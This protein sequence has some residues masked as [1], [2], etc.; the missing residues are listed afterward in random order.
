VDVTP[1]NTFIAF[2]AQ[3]G[4][5]ASDDGLYAREL[6][7]A[8]K[9]ARTLREA[10]DRA[11]QAGDRASN[12]KQRP[13][14]DDGLNADIGLRGGADSSPPQQLAGITPRPDPGAADDARR[15]EDD[16][17]AEAR[18]SDTV[19]AYEAYK[20]GYPS[21]RYVASANVAIARLKAASVPASSEGSWSTTVGSRPQ[22]GQTFRDC[23]D[24]PEM[25]VIPAGSF[26]MGSPASEVGRDKDEGPQRSVN[27]KSVAFG[28][29]HITRGQ[30]AAFVNAIS[31]D[32]GNSCYTFEGGK[33]EERTGRNWRN[34]GFTQSDNHP[35]VCINWEDAKAYAK[36]ISS[37][38]G[39]VYRL[40]TEAEWEYA[41]R[42]GT[43][44]ARYWGE[45][46]DQACGYANV[47]DQT[48]KSQIEGAS[49]LSIHNCTD[50]YAYTAPVGSFKPNAF[51]LNDMVGN[52]WQ[53]VEDCWHDDY[54][55]AP[56][57]GSA[58][59]TGANCG[60]RVLRGGSWNS[61]PQDARSADRNRITT[62]NRGFSVGFRLARMLP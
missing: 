19:A 9:E 62:T 18:K 34:P 49:G 11:G 1:S 16:T 38:T 52:A 31:H 7:R 35:V 47:A 57:D 41:A 60:Q 55:G 13:R 24:C 23:S 53:W 30:F 40:P 6:G 45:S 43:T 54:K 46:P 5:T 21:G 20:A 25:V 48:A 28:K 14:K 17:W 29:T 26:T 44:T 59:V 12:S 39:K 36:W 42:A 15:I 2:A 58:W 10:F 8:L 51:G 32:A 56:T 4:A 61:L 3:A 27:V 22:A 37:K 33:W 50:G